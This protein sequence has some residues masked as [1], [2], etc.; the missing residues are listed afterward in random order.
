MS[1]YDSRP[2]S[3]ANPPNT[4]NIGLNNNGNVNFNGGNYGGYAVNSHSSFYSWLNICF[5]IKNN[6]ISVIITKKYYL[7]H[8]SDSLIFHTYSYN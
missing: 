5:S 4:T 1:T 2:Y 6:I 8:L 3:V 7:Y